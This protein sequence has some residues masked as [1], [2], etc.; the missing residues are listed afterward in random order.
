VP[1]FSSVVIGR[2]DVG[3]KYRTL[4]DAE[5]EDLMERESADSSAVV[6]ATGSNVVPSG[7]GAR[8]R[9]S[10]LLLTANTSEHAPLMRTANRWR[11][12][13]A[14]IADAAAMEKGP[15]SS[16]VRACTS[17]GILAAILL[18]TKFGPCWCGRLLA[19]S[20]QWKQVARLV[21]LCCQIRTSASTSASHRCFLPAGV[22]HAQERGARE[23]QAQAQEQLR[24]GVWVVGGDLNNFTETRNSSAV[25]GRS[26]NEA[27]I[28]HRYGKGGAIYVLGTAG[29]G[30]HVGDP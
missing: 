13:G 12:D 16:Q 18:Q 19:R 21:L 2:A 8:A 20:K 29:G 6:V 14:Y 4:R 5:D 15:V 3:A 27:F 1:P 17:V 23:R 26:S 10:S 24:G 11:F 30:Q 28:C 22:E 7:G 9:R 25:A